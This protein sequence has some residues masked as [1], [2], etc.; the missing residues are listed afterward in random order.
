[1]VR[2]DLTPLPAWLS[3]DILLPALC[4]AGLFA[5]HGYHAAE[6]WFWSDEIMSVEAAQMTWRDLVVNRYNAA[7]SPLYFAF[8]KI[9]IYVAA[10][11]ES[12]APPSEF[13]IRLPSLVLMGLAGGILAVVVRKSWGIWAAL[14]VVAVWVL[15]YRIGYHATE[16][17]P[18]PLLMFFLAITIWAN[19]RLILEFHQG[20]GETR[21]VRYASFAAPAL[22]VATIPLG[23]IAAGL[24]EV[25]TFWYVWSSGSEPLKQRWRRR[26]KWVWP[27]MLGIF[28]TFLPIIVVKS[29]NYW[30]ERANPLS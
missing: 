28:A 11:F 6:V 9:W 18:Y 19:Q 14:L 22:A 7:H 16:A 4:V 12:S 30:L 29:D 23:F 8:L 17:R 3:G 15:H 21:W 13:V 26:I 2:G 5:V 20:S 10:G 1:M 25:G 24:I 27:I